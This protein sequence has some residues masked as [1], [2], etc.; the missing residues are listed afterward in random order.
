MKLGQS[1]KRK[2]LPS[3]EFSLLH[4]ASLAS[5][6]EKVWC[7]HTSFYTVPRCGFRGG[8][9][10]HGYMGTTCTLLREKSLWNSWNLLNMR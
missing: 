4:L 5:E 6:P 7:I 9:A 8:V 1:R 2:K 3:G 10:G